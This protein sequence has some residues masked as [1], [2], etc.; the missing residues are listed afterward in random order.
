M[1][2]STVFWRMLSGRNV[3]FYGIRRIQSAYGLSAFTV[4]L[5]ETRLSVFGR[6]AW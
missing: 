4:K 5:V 1:E 2:N 3:Q 6:L